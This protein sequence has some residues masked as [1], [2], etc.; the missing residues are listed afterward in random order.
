MLGNRS[1][2]QGW[3]EKA[4]IQINQHIFKCTHLNKWFNIISQTF[5]SKSMKIYRYKRC[6]NPNKKIVL[7]WR[8]RRPSNRRCGWEVG[9]HIINAEGTMDPR[10]ECFSQ[11]NCSNNS[12]KLETKTFCHGGA[13]PPQ[14]RLFFRPKQQVF[15]GPKT[16]FP[17]HF[18]SFR[19][20]PPS[21]QPFLNLRQTNSAN[22][23]G[24]SSGRKKSKNWYLG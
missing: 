14:I 18:S 24:Q 19:A 7:R 15:V 23:L 16:L 9:P 8:R 11:N 12:N 13:G 3:V 17:A 21:M 5:Q 20:L 6:R 22:G 10:V 4:S 1:I 2:Y